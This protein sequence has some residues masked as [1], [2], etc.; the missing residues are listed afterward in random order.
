[1]ISRVLCGFL[2]ARIGVLATV[3]L[4]EGL[5]A[6]GIL[7][8]LPL[9]FGGSLALLPLIGVALN[10]TSSV[11]YGTV[12]ELVP[13]RAPRDGIRRDD[14][15]R[16]RVAD[17]LWLAW[18]RRGRHPDDDVRR[19]RLPGHHSARVDDAPGACRTRQRS[20]MTSCEPYPR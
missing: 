3:Y 17:P 11:L 19:Y 6:A 10:G 1:M 15:Q 9:P 16:C 4:T 2:G 5:T 20:F 8:V 7:A 14:R 13:R 18:R 12:P